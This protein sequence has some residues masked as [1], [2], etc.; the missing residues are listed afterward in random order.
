MEK[1]PR[2]IVLSFVTAPRSGRERGHAYARVRRRL[3]IGESVL[4]LA[5]LLFWL[6][7]G[8]S[9]GLQGRL[10]EAVGS[11]YAT[12]ALYV[13]VFVVAMAVISLP[14]SYYSGLVLPRRH[15]L[16]HQSVGSWLVDQAKGLGIGVLFAIVALE[17]LYLLIRALPNLWWLP[18]AGAYLVFAVVLTNLAPVLL[19]PIF[20]KLRPL[21][22]EDLVQ[23]ARRLAEREGI[24]LVGIFT[25]DMSRRTSTTNAALTGL[26]NTRRMIVGDTMVDRYPDEEIETVLAH[27]LG[28]HVH[29]DIWKGIALQGLVTLGVLYVIFLIL[30]AFSAPLGLGAPSDIATLPLLALSFTLLNLILSP[31][32]SG[33]SRWLERK[34]DLYALCVSQPRAFASA[35]GRLADQN[36]AENKPPR[37]ADLI[38]A[39]HPSIADRIY[40][41]HN[42]ATDEEHRRQT[43]A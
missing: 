20:N 19:L 41:A 6:L 9:Q 5:Y 15:G 2:G 30:R 16:S 17:I 7:S 10:T 22:N 32:L 14:L 35:M 26:G 36:L 11:R 24:R 8:V 37:W 43:C 4:G 33:F 28:H 3:Y 39:D 42:L 21:E 38:L 40:L 13:L 31:F 34:A 29:G 25:M 1:R 18:A 27:E 12:I 23:R